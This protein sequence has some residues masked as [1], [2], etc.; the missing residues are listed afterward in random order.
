[1][2]WSYFSM[3]WCLF[4]LKTIKLVYFL[5]VFCFLCNRRAFR[6]MWN[7]IRVF[8]WA[9]LCGNETNE[10]VSVLQGR[11]KCKF[12]GIIDALNTTSMLEAAFWGSTLL[13]FLLTFSNICCYSSKW[14]MM[15]HLKVL[16]FYFFT[17]GSDHLHGESEN[18][19]YSSFLTTRV[20]RQLHANMQAP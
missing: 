20:T 18:T 10:T 14:F 9:L 13:C 16:L 15:A 2:N 12:T 17:V 8:R 3:T 11:I 6:M 4:T 19:G 7:Q 5:N 1:M